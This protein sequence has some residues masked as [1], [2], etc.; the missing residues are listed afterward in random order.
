MLLNSVLT[1][2]KLVLGLSLPVTSAEY[3]PNSSK[4]YVDILSYKYLA[5]SAK[6]VK[7]IIFLFSLFNGFSTFCF[8]NFCNSTNFLSLSTVILFASFKIFSSITLSASNS[9]SHLILSISF[10]CIL[11]FL[12]PIKTPSNLLSSISNSSI[13]KS[14]TKS[15]KVFIFSKVPSIFFNIFKTV[16]ANECIELSILFKILILIK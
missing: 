9:D 3:K 15:S 2:F 8:I 16:I 12:L 5:V 1:P 4:I 13:S 14:S 7:I 11:T 6:A 10:R